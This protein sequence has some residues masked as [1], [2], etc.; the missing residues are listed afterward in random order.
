MNIVHISASELKKSVA[1]V[2]DDVYFGRKIAVIKRY[3]KT[4]A[5]IVPVDREKGNKDIGILL[6][7]YFGILPEFPDV[8]KTRTFRRKNI[9]L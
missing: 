7:K 8:S 2:L 4:V 1:E 9:K 6:D 3:G 5:K